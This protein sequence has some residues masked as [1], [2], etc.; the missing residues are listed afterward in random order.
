MYPARLVATLGGAYL[1]L[2]IALILYPSLE[3]GN[4]LCWPKMYIRSKLPNKEYPSTT[5]TVSIF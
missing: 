4:P 5:I 2:I 1:P 3:P